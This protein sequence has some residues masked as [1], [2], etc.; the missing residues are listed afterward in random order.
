MPNDATAN[1]GEPKKDNMKTSISVERA[2]WRRFRSKAVANGDT[3][4][5][6]LEAAIRDY[7]GE[8]VKNE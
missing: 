4:T 2:L 5:E 6:I 1:Q 8:T 3:V 7:L